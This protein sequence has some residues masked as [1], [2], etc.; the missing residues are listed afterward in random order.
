[1]PRVFG[2]LIAKEVKTVSF[3]NVSFFCCGWNK[4]CL[5]ANRKPMIL[6]LETR[7][8]VSLVRVPKHRQWAEACDPRVPLLK[9][10]KLPNSPTEA[11]G[12]KR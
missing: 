11:I 8:N 10:V 1:M 4:K 12:R 5:T 9:V 7:R 2:H 6:D 3:D